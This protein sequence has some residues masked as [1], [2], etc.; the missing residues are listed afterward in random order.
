MLT[1]IVAGGWP[2][3][4]LIA[5]AVPLL[6]IAALFARSASPHRLSII[7]ALTTAMTFTAIG[8]VASD[9]AS[10]AYHVADNPDWLKDALPYVLEGFSESMAPIVLAFPLIAIAW[11]LVAFG[12]RRMPRDGQ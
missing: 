11:I 7:R 8:G 10:V 9:L 3:L 12:V 5:L 1:F 4:V 6:V 2:M